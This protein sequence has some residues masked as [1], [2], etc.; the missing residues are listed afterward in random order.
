MGDLVLW[1][2]KEQ[3]E[4]IAT[5]EI[6]FTKV[7]KTKGTVPLLGKPHLKAKAV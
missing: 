1:K 4:Q 6:C 5:G 2:P 7:E 3:A